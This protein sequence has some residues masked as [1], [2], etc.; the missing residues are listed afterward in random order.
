[1]T[2]TTLGYAF[3]G[4]LLPSF[5]WLYFLLKEDSKH[6]EPKALIA[7]AF[8][9]GIIAVPPALLLEQYTR[10]HLSGSWSILT[11]WA[12][13]EEVLKYVMAAIFILWRNAVD[14]APDYVIY[15]IT[16]ALGFAAAENMLFL[17]TPLSSGDIAS[18]VFTGNLRFLGSTLLHVVASSAIGFAFAFSASYRPTKRM[19][20]AALG[21]ILA[22]ALHTAFNALIINPGTSTAFTAFFLIWTVAVVFFAAFEVLKYFQYRKPLNYNRYV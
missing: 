8:I 22:T 3:L 21:L 13:I 16:V 1:M 7:F 10:T 17:L 11:S 5:I 4:G 6:P 12:L 20:A 9:A 19:L 15:M 14:E 18:S 2:S